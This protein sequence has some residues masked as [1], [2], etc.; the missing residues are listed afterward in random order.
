[1]VNV[2]VIVDVLDSR[3]SKKEVAHIL[4]AINRSVSPVQICNLCTT[5]QQGSVCE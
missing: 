1:M 2:I 3:N 4:S 5:T